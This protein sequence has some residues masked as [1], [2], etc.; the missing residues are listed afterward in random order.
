[1]ATS[2]NILLIDD[3][4]EIRIAATKTVVREGY[5]ITT[6]ATAE[7]GLARLENEN[8]D[9][10][11][12]DLFLPDINGI[13]VLTRARQLRPGLEVIVIT[14]HGTIETAV[15]A[16][17]LGAYDFIEKPF[18][19]PVLL[20]S[21]A[22]ALERQQLAAENR[23]LREQL[24]KQ[25]GEE[26]LVGTSAALRDLKALIRRIAAVDVS[27]LLRG[28]SGTGKEL[29]ANAL[30][31]L[32][33]RR[34]KSLVKISCAAIPEHLLESELFGYERGAFTGAVAS[35]P[36]RFELADGGTLFLDEI[37]EMST[38]L[39]A[40]LLRVLQDGTFQ[41]VGGTK[42]LRVDV[43]LV[44]ATHVDLA[45]AIEEKKF[46]E[47]LFYRLN[48]M[49][50]TVLPLRDRREDIPVLA[51]HFLAKHTAR[52]QKPVTA[53]APG[54]MDELLAHHWPGN[55][56]E[57]ENAVQ[58]AIAMATGDSI[59]T[60]Q[61]AAPTGTSAVPVGSAMIIPFGTPLVEAEERI[62]RETLQYC[63]GVKA[64]AAK[65]LGLSRRTL[66]RRFSHQ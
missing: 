60:F 42:E 26:A 30:H 28:E 58:R 47:D 15:E 54:A 37:A 24:Q 66:E 13:D 32:S 51:N 21:I 29:V 25:S 52:L 17:R 12:T 64:K 43:R 53:I 41:R 18:D 59:L 38:A 9:L 50:I 19:P 31:E 10:L 57:L 46:R 33:A 23:Q 16:M 40:K 55:V 8:A 39:Q 34:D 63:R 35:K 65:M 22:R 1:M 36:G 3:E 27:V 48:V 44:S 14:G 62:V 61:L 6:C 7:E 45:R 49:S 4:E 2:G 5:R 56:R 20:K 11:I